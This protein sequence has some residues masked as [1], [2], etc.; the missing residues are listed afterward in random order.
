MVFSKEGS[1][2]I[3]IERMQKLMARTDRITMEMKNRFR[4]ECGT[5]KYTKKQRVFWAQQAA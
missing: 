2:T 5:F 1:M 3:K 4:W